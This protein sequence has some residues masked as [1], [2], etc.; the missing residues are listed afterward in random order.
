MY[1]PVGVQRHLPGAQRDRHRRV[2]L[3]LG[4]QRSLRQHVVLL[5]RTALVGELGVDVGARNHLHGAVAGVGVVDRQPH[6]DGLAGRQRPVGGVLVPAHPLAVAGL[7]EEEVGAPQD[8]VLAEQILYRIQDARLGAQVV[9]A[10][11]VAVPAVDAVAAVPG[12][13]RLGEQVVAVGAHR[14]HLP[15]AEQLQREQVTQLVELPDLR[16]AQHPRVR[17]PEREELANPVILR[18][19]HHGAEQTRLPWYGQGLDWPCAALKLVY[20]TGKNTYTCSMKE[21]LH[22]T[23]VSE[24]G[25]ITIPKALRESLGIRPGTVLELT[26]VRGN[27]IAQKREADDPLLKWRGRGRLPGGETVDAYLARIRR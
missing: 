12:G 2:A 20:H 10:G 9:E 13:H 24:K 26:A 4:G 18:F 6:G 3:L 19:R 21:K 8:Q 16:R 15:R 25:Q 7:L 23:T 1:Q 22:R 17:H 14:R 11:A 5:R 27:L